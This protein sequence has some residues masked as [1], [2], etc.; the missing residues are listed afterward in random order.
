[1]TNCDGA[2]VDI[3]FV[4][5]PAEVLVDGAG[6][7][8]KSFIGFDKI[9]V[10]DIPAGLLERRTRRRYRASAHDFRVDAGLRPG[11]DARQRHL[12]EL[13]RFARLH[14]YHRGGAVIDAGRI[15]GG[16]SAFLVESGPQF[17]DRIKRRAV[18]GIFVGV[19]ND[20]ALAGFYGNGRDL[21]LEPAGLLRRFSLVL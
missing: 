1:M 17:A 2:A 13:G 18:L 19:D 15:A 8:G 7:R 6:L 20:V 14:Q 21:V 9:E 12:A 16:Y 3:Y 10:A 11:H 5:I 4:G